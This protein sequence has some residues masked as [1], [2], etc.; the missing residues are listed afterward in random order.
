MKTNKKT[1]YFLETKGTKRIFE[2]AS[3][4]IKFSNKELRKRGLD[5]Q[6]DREIEILNKRN[7]L[8]LMNCKT[9]Q[10]LTIYAITI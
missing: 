10:Y 7:Q 9:S 5:L 1:V 3:K 8:I 4:V 2:D 6:M